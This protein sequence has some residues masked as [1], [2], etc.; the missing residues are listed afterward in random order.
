[1]SP[2][3][4]Y[5][6]VTVP[7]PAPL[8]QRSSSHGHVRVHVH[9]TVR[10]STVRLLAAPRPAQELPAYPE[11]LAAEVVVLRRRRRAVVARRLR[12]DVHLRLA[13]G[14]RGRGRR[15]RTARRLPIRLRQLLYGLDPVSAATDQRNLQHCSENTTRIK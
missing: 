3:R 6:T 15:V 8:V 14:L 2:A 11:H 5:H 7:H 12:L 9:G 10:L 1:M 13:G 4:N